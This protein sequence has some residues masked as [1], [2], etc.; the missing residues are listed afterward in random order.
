M[1]QASDVDSKRSQSRVRDE[2]KEL[3]TSNRDRQD[4][5]DEK[6]YSVTWDEHDPKKSVRQFTRCS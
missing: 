3:E 5:D 4:I 2:E 6:A 1:S